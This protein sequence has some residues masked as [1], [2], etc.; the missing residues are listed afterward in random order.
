MIR[1]IAAFLLFFISGQ[2]VQPGG[3]GSGGPVGFDQITSGTN[4]AHGLVCGAGCVMSASGGGFINANEINGVLLS[5]L[6]TGLYKFTAGVPSAATFADLP[7]PP[8][9]SGTTVTF[10]AGGGYFVCTGACTITVPVPAAGLQVCVQNN[11]AVT[12]IITFAAIGSSARY[13]NTA[14]TAYGTATTGTLVSGGAAGDKMC[15]L[16]IDSTH[17]NVASFNGTWVAS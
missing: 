11:V 7:L 10:N 9:T 1:T 16:G 14:Q 3:G 4:L 17:Y 2:V 5:G 15:L 8:A 12:S 13:G 6:A